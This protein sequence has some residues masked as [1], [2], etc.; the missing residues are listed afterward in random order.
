[1]VCCKSEPP[2]TTPAP[3]RAAPAESPATPA[4]A[5]WT[6][7]DDGLEHATLTIGDTSIAAEVFAASL[8]DYRLV[9]VDAR[10][11]DGR[12]VAP[13]STLREESGATV[14]VNGTFF[15]REQAPMGLLHQ[16]ARELNPLRDADWGVL[17]QTQRGGARLV[18]TRDYSPDP[19]RWF[20]VQC[21]PRVVIDGAP[22]KLKP[23]SARRTAVCLRS[24]NEVLLLVVDASVDASVLAQWMATAQPEGL[25]CRDAMLLDGGPSTQLSAE[26]GEFSMAVTGGWGVPNAIGFSRRIPAP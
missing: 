14:L 13:V 5:T 8:E 2:D 10:R 7:I 26:R 20:A 6:E 21:G 22:P 24:Q 12:T 16:G 23:Q 4:T 9:A 18:H 17:E 11:A 1:M 19:T 3:A 15:D 25:A